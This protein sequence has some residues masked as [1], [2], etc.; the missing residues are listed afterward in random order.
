MYQFTS[1][2]RDPGDPKSTR[3]GGPVAFIAVGDPPDARGCERREE[4]AREG[5]RGRVGTK[6]RAAPRADAGA[7][8]HEVDREAEHAAE[9]AAIAEAERRA[10]ISRTTTRPAEISDWWVPSFGPPGVEN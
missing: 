7:P 9:H 4:A 1:G 5:R 8:R 2:E 3:R 10:R 6:A